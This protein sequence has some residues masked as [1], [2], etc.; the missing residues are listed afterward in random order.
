MF[1]FDVHM[2]RHSES[3]KAEMIYCYCFTN[4]YL[5]PNFQQS[6]SWYSSRCI[7]FCN[8]E[9]R[10]LIYMI[11]CDNLHG[12]CCLLL[13]LALTCSFTRE[14]NTLLPDLRRLFIVTALQ[15][16]IEEIYGISKAESWAFQISSLGCNCFSLVW[17]PWPSFPE[18]LHSVSLLKCQDLEI[19]VLH[20]LWRPS[21]W[22]W[23]GTVTLI[24]LQVFS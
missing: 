2:K 10:G 22:F 6:A 4:L 19:K 23:K 20:S 16:L 18:V 15:Y 24:P 17:P 8:T 21:T 9:S 14:Y 11:S 13:I 1:G 7:L 5:N 3:A 12:S